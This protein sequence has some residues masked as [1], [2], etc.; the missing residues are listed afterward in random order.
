MLTVISKGSD[1]TALL[2][3]SASGSGVNCTEISAHDSG[4]ERVPYVNYPVARGRM[5]VA[6]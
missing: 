2:I 3:A 5:E 1:V 6:V 4:L